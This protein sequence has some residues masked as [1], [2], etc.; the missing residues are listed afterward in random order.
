MVYSPGVDSISS[1]IVCVMSGVMYLVSALEIKA[2]RIKSG[3]R[4]LTKAMELTS[5]AEISGIIMMFVPID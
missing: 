4:E 1:R 2:G 3:L 5:F